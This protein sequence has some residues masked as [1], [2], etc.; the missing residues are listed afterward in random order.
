[1]E[2]IFLVI[3]SSYFLIC[4]KIFLGG[5]DEYVSFSSFFPLSIRK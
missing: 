3:F 5:V 1:M 4:D 2:K